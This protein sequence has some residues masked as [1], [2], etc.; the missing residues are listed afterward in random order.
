MTVVQTCSLPI[1]S[2]SIG[3]TL[4][5][6]TLGGSEGTI[7]ASRMLQPWDE[8]STWNRFGGDGIHAAGV[9]ARS[10]PS[11]TIV[12][13]RATSEI[14][15]DVTDDVVFWTTGGTNEGYVFIT[16]S[17]D[18]WSFSSSEASNNNPTLDITA[19]CVGTP[20]VAPT[21]APAP[22]APTPVGGGGGSKKKSS[23]SSGT[24]ILI[25]I[26]VVVIVGVCLIAG[27]IF[28]VVQKKQRSEGDKI[29]PGHG[30][31]EFTEIEQPMQEAKK[32]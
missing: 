29:P 20:T 9:E 5:L 13:P 25:V 3:A 1:C 22:P 17:T 10:V 32:K 12:S 28:F 7:N 14:S 4:R 11:F 18:A 2:S 31:L 8:S 16:D 21:P 30:N 6:F 15:F 23:N 19:I 24:T 27:A 26:I